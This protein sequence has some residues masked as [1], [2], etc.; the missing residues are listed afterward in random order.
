MIFQRKETQSPDDFW[1]DRERDKGGP[2][3]FK[4]FSILLGK[5]D[6]SPQ[7]LAGI[8]YQ[9]NDT[10]YFED[11]EKDNMLAKIVS[12]NR[13]YEKTEFSFLRS[14][15]REMRLVS[16]N[17]ALS[18]IEGSLRDSET[19]PFTTLGSLFGKPA[20]QLMFVSGYSLFFDVMEVKG[21]QAL[22]A[23]KA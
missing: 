11:F 17:A 7:N 6:D 12:R 22:F 10:M 13:K 5:S 21:L 8:L 19:K 1:G 18:S 2:V 3:G 16:K 20:V 4:S 14:D 23:K 9:V 15:V